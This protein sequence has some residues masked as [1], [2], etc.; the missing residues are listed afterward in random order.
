MAQLKEPYLYK[1]W[2]M[3]ALPVPRCRTWNVAR[4]SPCTA[5]YRRF[6]DAIEQAC[7]RRATGG[8]RRAVW[9]ASWAWRA[10]RW[11][12][13]S[14]QLMGEGYP[15]RARP[16]RVSP[17]LPAAARMRPAGRHR[18]PWRQRPAWRRMAF[19]AAPPPFQLGMPALD[20]PRAS[21]GCGWRPGGC[22][23]LSPADMAYGDPAGYWPL[24]AGDR[25]LSVGFERRGLRTGAGRHGGP[26]GQSGIAGAR[27][28]GARR[29]GL[30]GRTGFRAA[31]R[32]SERHSLPS[33]RCRSMAKV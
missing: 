6:R 3:K 30:G 22:A 11:D 18:P 7:W 20:A 15:A 9:P 32:G 26:S 5:R 17:R 33:R 2:S 4:A 1:N 28:A 24:A 12:L 19:D 27:A 10:A 31:L 21:S 16:A 25:G 13:A 8:R 29:S 23:P 14:S